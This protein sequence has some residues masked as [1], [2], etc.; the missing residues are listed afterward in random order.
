MGVDVEE[1][2]EKVEVDIRIEEGEEG[3]EEE[4]RGGANGGP[5]IDLSDLEMG[6]RDRRVVITSDKGW[7]S[8]AT[9]IWIA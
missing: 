1:V 5:L 7:K 8:K 3:E 4:G 2:A 6:D 9:F